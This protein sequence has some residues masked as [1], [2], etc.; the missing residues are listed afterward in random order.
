MKFFEEQSMTLTDLE[1]QRTLISLTKPMGGSV[2]IVAMCFDF[3][4]WCLHFGPQLM[5]PVLQEIDR[6]FGLTQVYRQAQPIPYYCLVTVNDKFCCPLVQPDGEPFE[7]ELSTRMAKHWMEGLS[8]KEWNCRNTYAKQE[9]F[10]CF[11]EECE[12]IG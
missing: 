7:S 5:G 10:S 12:E 2:E 6:F 9:A 11:P 3:K 4:R 8:Q 1:L